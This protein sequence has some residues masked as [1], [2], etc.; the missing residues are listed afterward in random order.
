MVEMFLKKR[1]IKVP[2]DYHE[3]LLHF[4]PN[5]KL[6]K[7]NDNKLIQAILDMYNVKS[8][9]TVKYLHENLRVNITL[10]VHMC[11]IFGDDYYHYIPKINP[12]FFIRDDKNIGSKYLVKVKV[13]YELNKDEKDNVLSLINNY[14]YRNDF[15]AGLDTLLIDHLEMINKVRPFEPNLKFTPRNHIDFTREHS[16][17]SDIISKI[18]K[19]WTIEYKFE[20]RML[21][22]VESEIVALRD[23]NSLI[24]FKPYVLKRDDDY[25]EEGKFMHH[26]VAGYSVKDKSIIISLRTL[27]GKDRVTCEYHIQTGQRLQARYFS[28]QNPP[29]HFLDGLDIL[30]D[31]VKKYSKFALLNWRD[32]IK[33]PVKING[34]EV[35]ISTRPVRCFNDVLLEDPF[36]NLLV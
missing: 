36:F 17:L 32:K 10:F 11:H 14:L 3:L 30:D 29:D 5:Q 25:I 34:I 1:G 18:N 26:C 31:K 9:S 35:D 33:V 12:V 15:S 13:D 24:T 8:K 7:K 2:N 23:Y 16:R 19:G 20:E 6:L 22:D 4:Y 27:D 28:N 21:N